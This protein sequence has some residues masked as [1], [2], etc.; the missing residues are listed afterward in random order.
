MF[1]QL[2]NL[3]GL[4]GLMK[5]VGQLKEQFAQLQQ[6]LKIVRVEAETGGGAVK[7]VASGDLRIVSI[8]IDP[9]MLAVLTDAGDEADRELA[10]DL[11]VGAVNGALSKARQAAAEGMARRAGELGIALP[12]GFDLGS[13]LGSG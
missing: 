6:E 4:S 5:N 1:D 10:Q 7:A 11:I 13:L 2:R 8:L 9:T 3:S 12:P